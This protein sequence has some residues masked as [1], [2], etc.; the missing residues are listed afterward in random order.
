MKQQQNKHNKIISCSN[1]HKKNSIQPLFSISLHKKGFKVIAAISMSLYKFWQQSSVI[2]IRVRLKSN[3]SEV[4][5]KENTNMDENRWHA[6][7]RCEKCNIE[8]NDT[9]NKEYGIP[10]RC[11]KCGKY[12]TPYSQVSKFKGYNHLIRFV[13]IRTVAS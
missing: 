5:W 12:T 13:L 9:I 10:R 3:Q 2:A 1:A 8:L 6:Y 7:Y 4:K 11:Y